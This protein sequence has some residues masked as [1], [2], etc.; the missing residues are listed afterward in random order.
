[1]SAEPDLEND[2]RAKQEGSKVL[3]MVMA[4]FTTISAIFVSLAIYFVVAYE[5]PVGFVAPMIAFPW[6]AM[7]MMLIFGLAHR[8]KPA[9]GT[10]SDWEHVGETTWVKPRSLRAGY[11]KGRSRGWN[12][13][14]TVEIDD[15]RYPAIA[16]ISS[17]ILDAL[18]IVL[19]IL[20]VTTLG[21][22]LFGLVVSCFLKH[23]AWLMRKDIKKKATKR[24]TGA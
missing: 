19:Y 11:F 21:G 16:L 14:A 13:K 15:P 17:L 8:E 24:G 5:E 23:L 18:L 12:G 6:V 4:I 20:S 9:V 1:V 10:T 3:L 22:I 2:R 7:T